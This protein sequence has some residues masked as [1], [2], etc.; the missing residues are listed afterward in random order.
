MKEGLLVVRVAARHD[1]AVGR[2]V[3]A[4]LL[5]LG[6]RGPTFGLLA[7]GLDRYNGQT[8]Y[9]GDV[10]GSIAVADGNIFASNT[11]YDSFAVV[12]TDQTKGIEVLQENRPIG[13][14]GTE[15]ESG[16]IVRHPKFYA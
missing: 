1:Q 9:R 12:D 13:K 7:A 15:T 11:I 5:E 8:A 3:D 16:I 10:Q 4:R 14:T 2:T 6:K